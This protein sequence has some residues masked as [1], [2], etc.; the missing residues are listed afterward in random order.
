MVWSIAALAAFYAALHLFVLPPDGFFCGDQGPKYLQAR[1][2]ADRGILAPWIEGPARDVDPQSR[3]VMPAT[4][5]RAD[6]HVVSVFTWLLPVLTAPL[7]KA[8]GL[9]GLYVIPALSAIVLFVAARDLGR[10]LGVGSG[11]W[12][13]WTAVAATPVLFYGAEFWDHAPAAAAVM[14]A[15]NVLAPGAPVT[16]RRGVAAGAALAIGGL[17]REEALL[18]APA[19]LVA[20]VCVDAACSTS[21]AR[22]VFGPDTVTLAL[23]VLAGMAAVFLATLPLNHVVY[24]AWSPYH[25]ISEMAK[26]APFFEQRSLAIRELLL[27]GSSLPLFGALAAAVVV[28]AWW[29]QAPGVQLAIAHVSVAGLILLAGILPL[30]RSGFAGLITFY[31]YR[32]SSAAY[33]W[34]FVIALVYVALLPREGPRT[35]VPG[36]L[37]IAG[38]AI[39]GLAIALTPSTGGA[40][41]GPRYLLP[42]APLLAV[43][44]PLAQAPVFR[45]PP[46]RARGVRWMARLVIAVSILIQIDGLVYLTDAKRMNGRIARTTAELA[47]PGDIVI[48]DLSW[49]PQ[50]VAT[51]YDTRPLLLAWTRDQVEDIAAAAA[52]GGFDRVAI[53]VS[54]PLTGYA[55]PDV[56]RAPGTGAELFVRAG[57]VEY[58]ERALEFHRYT[59]AAVTRGA[60]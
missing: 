17:F 26:S 14:V 50:L 5:R 20:R 15:A 51:L 16:V 11:L 4:L 55:P 33:T 32:I 18:A 46:A 34:P 58:G 13:A 8:F 6:N 49:Y 27:P 10:K 25:L 28:F 42:A 48:S 29:K 36:Y 31:A 19:L 37:A 44:A 38:L 30:W 2:V 57:R 1:A 45:L 54:P 47:P 40:Q 7:L 22:S 21:R 60:R 52:A 35:A 53:V 41:W 59:R 9:R 23:P 56:L 43:L 24:G 12:S 3:Y 39:A